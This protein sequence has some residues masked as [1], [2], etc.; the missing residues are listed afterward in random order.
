MTQ[1]EDKMMTSN[2]FR[3]ELEKLCQGLVAA[4]QWELSKIAEKLKN[5]F[6]IWVKE[7]VE[8]EPSQPDKMDCAS[9]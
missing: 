5:T 3:Q 1:T 7:P 9:A 8:I 4:E 2:E 6:L